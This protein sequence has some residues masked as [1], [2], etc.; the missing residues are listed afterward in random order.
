[1]LAVASDQALAK[2]HL[3][4]LTPLAAAITEPA[5]R[6]DAANKLRDLQ[7]ALDTAVRQNN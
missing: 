3:L 5:A 4:A 7:A 1:M 2:A 6:A